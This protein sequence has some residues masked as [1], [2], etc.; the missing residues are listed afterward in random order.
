[1]PNLA[2]VDDE[3][4]RRRALEET[5]GAPVDLQAASMPPAQ[6]AAPQPPVDIPVREP[7]APPTDADIVRSK[8][9]ERIQAESKPALPSAE[10]DA[11]SPPVSM[12]PAGPA[13]A[14]P[15]PPSTPPPTRPTGPAYGAGLTDADLAR[16]Y[17]AKRQADSEARLMNAAALINRGFGG[18]MPLNAG[19]A[20]RA[21][22]DSQVQEI[23]GRR[24]AMDAEQKRQ[25]EEY[26]RKLDAYN[27]DPYAAPNQLVRA[28][29]AQKHPVI[30]QFPEAALNISPEKAFALDI[31]GTKAA[32]KGGSALLTPEAADAV[33]AHY[34][35]QWNLGPE[36]QAQV[37]AVLTTVP[38]V[39]LQQK[40]LD[41]I[42]GHAKLEQSKTASENALEAS[43][44]KF[45]TKRQ[46]TKDRNFDTDT[47]KL[48]K[49]IGKETPVMRALINRLEDA[50][51]A[52]R[53][54]PK[55]AAMGGKIPGIGIWNQWIAN[56]PG[57]AAFAET[58][59]GREIR[60]TLQGMNAIN[61]KN[62]TGAAFSVPEAGEYMTNFANGY[63]LDA[64]EKSVGTLAT[65]VDAQLETA[66]AGHGGRNSAVVQAFMNNVPGLKRTGFDTTPGK[67]SEAKPQVIEVN[68]KRYRR[69]PN[70]EPVEIK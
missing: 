43:K 34:A 61:R 6:A 64:L 10:P 35:T 67:K 52:A 65:M 18:S 63:S 47:Q 55:A 17:M 56:K 66:F 16:A 44:N 13:P 9:L 22:G 15:P 51:K 41:Q 5:G 27:N 68:G 4:A 2:L 59:A 23:Q 53:S 50:V 60:D 36:E 46:D 26:Q 40:A 20:Y 45:D 12:A 37:R 58:P 48:A 42:Q 30:N 25:D 24:A 11:V 19:D 57:F 62:I 3:E 70:G 31:A 33:T 7:A 69:G 14:T 21:G 29:L 1:M 28:V 54:D 38:D 49:D 32:G 39:K 8:L